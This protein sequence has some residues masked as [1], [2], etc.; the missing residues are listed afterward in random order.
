MKAIFQVNPTLTLELDFDSQVDLFQKLAT[1]SEV[2]GDVVARDKEGNTSD[3]VRFVART[4]DDN[5]YFELQCLDDSQPKLKYAKKKF[6]VKKG[7]DQFLFPK[8]NWI[9][10]DK[11][12]QKEIDLSTGKPVEDKE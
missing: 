11:A 4:V 1:Y 5:T 9:K 2:F 10:Y 6:G 12:S 3:K 8:S 7:K